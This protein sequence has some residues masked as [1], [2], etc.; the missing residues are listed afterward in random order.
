MKRPFLYAI[1]IHIFLFL[2]FFLGHKTPYQEVD[3]PVITIT[4]DNIIEQKLDK[5][6]EDIEIKDKENVE[7]VTKVTGEKEIETD[8][9]TNTELENEVIS[10]P[11]NIEETIEQKDNNSSVIENKHQQNSTKAAEVIAENIIQ[12]EMK[13]SI[14]DVKSSPVNEIVADEV[15]DKV[16][17]INEPI[18][19]EEENLAS[20]NHD[21]EKEDNF[22]RESIAI[23]DSSPEVESLIT[24]AYVPEEKINLD[25]AEEEPINLQQS[26]QKVIDVVNKDLAKIEEQIPVPV[27]LTNKEPVKKE[28]QI[29][30]PVDLTNKMRAKKEEQI[31]SPVDLTNEEQ[32]K[33]EEEIPV[34]VDLTN[35]ERIKTEEQTSLVLDVAAIEKE[36]EEVDSTPV[37]NDKK[38]R[39]EIRNS[40]ETEN[41]E[42]FLRNISTKQ[43]DDEARKQLHR[44]E[45]E[46]LKQC[47]ETQWQIIGGSRVDEVVIIF[48]LNMFKDGTIKG[49]P[50]IVVKG[51]HKRVDMLESTAKRAIIACSPF[52]LSS[53]RY[54][55]WEK[56]QINF[57]P[58]GY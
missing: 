47:L 37:E 52:K 48:Y 54:D 36:L 46:G 40:L 39:T 55:L 14:P 15:A 50:L 27:D 7:F 41:V 51:V 21:K 23:K 45:L 38:S 18:D 12:E 5:P 24:Q 25:L 8:I 44:A 56:I 9:E 20:I 11:A 49:E 2:A 57:Y 31:S 17:S 42:S 32:V 30:I 16:D 53:E 10:F 3:K 34:P 1:L 13:E 22:L 28:E 4:L 58:N 43:S 35:K 26:E 29:P 33:K 6:L 19:G